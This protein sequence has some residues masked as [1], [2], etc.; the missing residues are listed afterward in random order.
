MLIGV[1]LLDMGSTSSPTGLEYQN[2]KIII[3]KYPIFDDNVISPDS[4]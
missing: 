2:S 4:M 3:P 1:F